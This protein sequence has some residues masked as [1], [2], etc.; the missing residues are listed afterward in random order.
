MATQEKPKLRFITAASLFDGHD[1]AINIMRRV[2]QAQG[3]EVIHRPEDLSS[4]SLIDEHV[5]IIGGA[6][7]YDVFLP[8]LDELLVSHVFEAHEGDT[9]FPE[10]EHH[11]SK[12]EVVETYDDFELRRYTR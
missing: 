5:F 2:M 4:L 12:V 7:I 3:A 8:H 11:F 10:F 9:R 1:A 6:Q